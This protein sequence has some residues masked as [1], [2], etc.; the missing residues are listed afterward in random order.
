MHT[1][2]S[3]NRYKNHRFPERAQAAQ[4]LKLPFLQDAQELGI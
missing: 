3:T 1:P 2:L 4:A